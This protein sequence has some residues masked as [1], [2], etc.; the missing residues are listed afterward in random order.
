MGVDD[1]NVPIIRIVKTDDSIDVDSI[2]TLNIGE[3]YRI[4]EGDLVEDVQIANII[5]VY[6]NG[7]N[8]NRVILTQPVQ[9]KKTLYNDS[10]L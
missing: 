10:I 1:T 3:H 9:N 2:E 4:V 7:M 6:S 5:P 8:L